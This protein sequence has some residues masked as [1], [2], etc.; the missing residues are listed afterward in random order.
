MSAGSGS[1]AMGFSSLSG[2]IS[3][4]NALR[5][6]GH[7][8]KRVA[9]TNAMIAEGQATRA[10]SRGQQ[11]ARQIRRQANKVK[12][13]KRALAAAEGQSFEDGDVADSLDETELAAVA[14]VQTAKTNAYLEAW[15]F[16]VNARNSAA[17]GKFAQMSNE[18]Q[19][20]STILTG[21]MQALGY[22]L[23]G[24]GKRSK[25]SGSDPTDKETA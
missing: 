24:A 17:Q 8:Q 11:T 23:E 6:Q 19:A 12:A 15:G 3:N 2:A 18:N 22:G 13:E 4:A 25:G 21:G 5:A 10:E 1:L 20:S 7:Y 9:E 14:D 16:R